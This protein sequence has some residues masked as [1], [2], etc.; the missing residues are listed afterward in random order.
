MFFNLYFSTTIFK[1]RKRY[2]RRKYNSTEEQ[3]SRL[4][5]YNKEYQ[6]AKL[7][8]LELQKFKTSGKFLDVGCS[9]GI[10][11]KAAKDAGFDAYGIEPTQHAAKYAKKSFTNE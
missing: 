8:I 4:A 6:R 2:Q 10:G 11:V 7:H 3:E 9:Y 5:I 1:I